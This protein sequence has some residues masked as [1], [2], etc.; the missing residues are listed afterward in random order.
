MRR[1]ATTSLAL[2]LL[3]AAGGGAYVAV[4]VLR[5]GDRPAAEEVP[6]ATVEGREPG[7]PEAGSLPGLAS[8]AAPGGTTAP[9]PERAAGDPPKPSAD[10]EAWIDWALKCLADERHSVRT[11]GVQGLRRLGPRAARAIPTLVA[12]F[13]DDDERLRS[14]LAWTLASI[15]EA[16]VPACLEAAAD[17]DP[18]ARAGAATALGGLPT[19]AARSVPVLLAR[20]KDEDAD[21]RVAAAGAFGAFGADARF[22]VPALVAALG[23]SRR[24]K[25]VAAR[26]LGRLRL[27]APTVV[28]ALA[29]LAGDASENEDVRSAAS[30]AIGQMG[31]Y[32]KDAVKDLVA[33][34]ES[35][36]LIA[37]GQAFATI[38]ALG[39]VAESALPSLVRLAEGEDEDARSLA[40]SA[41]GS[42][43]PD[44][45]RALAVFAKALAGDHG[46]EGVLAAVGLVRAGKAGLPA[47]RAAV[48]DEALRSRVER[49]EFGP[50]GFG[51][52]AGALDILVALLDEEHPSLRRV[53]LRGLSQCDA[54]AARAVPAVAR[55]LADEDPDIR[56]EVVDVLGQIGK[57][58]AT[59]AAVLREAT[60]DADPGVRAQAVTQLAWLDVKPDDALL[61][62]L[63]AR[64]ADGA[65]SVRQSAVDALGRF[66]PAAKSALPALRQR[67]QDPDAY[68]R[69][70][71]AGAIRRITGP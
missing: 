42:V 34:A 10:D 22:A 38:S 56:R 28:P 71:A 59:V 69:L 7:A 25:L 3:A 17:A 64:L 33:A 49:V 43:R 45:E 21:V 36:S 2:L 5:D 30:W 54:S 53:G 46:G 52:P 20:M 31:D 29:R 67:L 32:A 55:R 16:A 12:A 13:H 15:G 70:L 35:E 58:S 24:M 11:Q 6:P 65:E 18:R 57:G 9:R 23:E 51:D 66:G 37:R 40:L 4:G 61:A 1:A 39:P 26:T 27:E 41:L 44:D 8:E 60:V 68:V 14:E 48:A 19:A 63:V 62:A 47:L 50:W